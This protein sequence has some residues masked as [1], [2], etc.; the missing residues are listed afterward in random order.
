[1]LAAT[2]T[3][4][5]NTHI[6]LPFKYTLLFSYLIVISLVIEITSYLQRQAP[7]WGVRRVTESIF[8]G[9]AS[10][11]PG[12]NTQGDF[13]NAGWASRTTG[14]LITNCDHQGLR[15]TG[16]RV[17]TCRPAYLGFPHART[18]MP[19]EGDPEEGRG[20]RELA[21]TVGHRWGLETLP[22]P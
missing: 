9:T 10:R 5:I 14:I 6:A 13:V 8:S 19:V 18:L 4:L 2:F 22:L 7:Q 12:K 15:V 1:M 11:S 3:T 21:V 20:G 16:V 17:L